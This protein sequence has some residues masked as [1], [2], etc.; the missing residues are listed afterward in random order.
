[1]SKSEIAIRNGWFPRLLRALKL[2]DV[3]DDG[4][5]SHIAGSDFIGSE[6]A[7]PSYPAINSMS[8][9]AA[10]PWVRACVEAISSDLTKVPIRVLRGRGKDAEPVEDHPVLDLI[11]R[12]SSR[13]PGILL[14]R[15]IIV[16]LVLTGDAYVLRAG[17]GEPLALIR[18]HPERVKIIPTQDGQPHEYEFNGGGS[19]VRY[20]FDQVL[21]IRLPSWQ[22]TPTMLYGTGA[23]EALQHDLNT[24]LAAAKLA[25]ESASTGLPTGIIS[26]SEEGDRWS[27]QQISQLR[28]GFEKQLKSKSGTVILGAGVDYRQLSQTLR[29]MEYQNTRLLAREATLASF[30][31]PP[32]RVGL[33]NANYAT[34]MAQARLYWEGL[35]G[36]AALIDSELTRLARMFPD[37][38]DVRVM[39][40][41]SEVDALQESRTER[42]NRV[43]TWWLM[44]VELDQ[45]AALEGFD[46]LDVGGV[47]EEPPEEPEADE[48]DDRTAS[49]IR[50]ML[51][52]SSVTRGLSD[53]T[54][55]VQQ[56][57][58][59]KAD[60]HNED[61]DEKGMAEWRK[62]TAGTLAKVFERGVGAYETNPESVRP[63]VTSPEQ[64]A[65]ARVNSFLYALRN[66]KY[67]SGK[68]DTDLLPDEHP[69]ASAEKA[70]AVGDTNPTNFPQEGDDSTVSLR[71]SQWD[72][73]DLEFAAM[74][75]EKYPKIW[76]R[77]GNIKGNDQYRKLKPIAEN[78]GKVTTR[79]EEAAV[80]LREA[81]GARH[82][83]DF[84]LAGVVAQMKWLV[85]GSRGERYMKNLIID[86]MDRLD[87][88]KAVKWLVPDNETRDL[89]S[90]AGRD[91]VWRGFIDRVHGPAEKK[92][93]LTMRRYLRAQA[94]RIAKRA[95]KEFGT[96]GIRKAID[97][98]VLDRILDEPYEKQQLLGLFRPL[99]RD[100][101]RQA[102][103][104]AAR[105][106]RLELSIDREQ[107]ER[108]ALAAVRK[109][110]TSIL[111][112]TRGEVQDIVNQALEENWTLDEIQSS[113]VQS[114]KF[115]ATRAMLI[116][117]T[118][119]TRHS[120]R[121]AVDAFKAAEATGIKVEKMWLSARDERV[122]DAHKPGGGLDGQTVPV[123]GL[124]N[125]QGKTSEH[126]GGFEDAAMDI[127]CRCTVV[128]KVVN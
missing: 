89:E 19:T 45:A 114:K 95:G 104:E 39:H 111:A 72:V 85:V 66:D 75:K 51:D 106:L 46:N 67:R 124:F 76:Q 94:S 80:R 97:D 34:A 101:L 103:E 99:Y 98:R 112:T 54:D 12:P 63:S 117:R 47:S 119:T 122:R 64:W 70:R 36:K 37:S 2:V 27:R 123:D 16:D 91:A 14:R 125:W 38:D 24:D 73:F 50:L 22:Q 118:E 109:M 100:L 10:F 79:G 88:E 102:F 53:L 68:H 87:A 6:P 26:P 21:H 41:F 18:L 30:G 113:L 15:Q 81:W 82:F 107:I 90:E 8:A 5:T 3:A 128:G 17:K 33:P 61:V 116:A 20:G 32:S 11:D 23:I 49:L 44:G 78:G 25:A 4:Q 48:V 56:G 115:D 93:A 31:V 83:E 52:R 60:E 28:E 108:D 62:T 86:E 120:N 7:K 77:G 105:S 127:N 29:D 71:T 35:Q 96:K 110:E 42:V 126:P 84:R 9:M 74:I 65:Y 92:M 43:Q 55:A 58:R 1:M 121:A 13:V 40:D 69:M 59:N 57:L